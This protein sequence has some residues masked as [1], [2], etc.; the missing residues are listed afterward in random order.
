MISS[1]LQHADILIHGLF[2]YLSLLASSLLTVMCLY[3]HLQA[4]GWY[5][6]QHNPPQL[7]NPIYIP[8]L[9]L[10]LSHLTIKSTYSTLGSFI[11]LE[12]EEEYNNLI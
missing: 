2:R 12:A 3:V 5:P 7:A 6:F 1:F 9:H 10:V 11:W 8:P 4:S